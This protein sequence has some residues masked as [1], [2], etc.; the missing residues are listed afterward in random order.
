MA[1]TGI[2]AHHCGGNIRSGNL[3]VT[4]D[5]GI[6]QRDDDISRCFYFLDRF[7]CIYHIDVNPR[8]DRRPGG[9]KIFIVAAKSGYDRFPSGRVDGYRLATD[10]VTGRK[11]HIDTFYNIRIAL[12]LFDVQIIEYVWIITVINRVR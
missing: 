1:F 11:D 4:A 5:T 9:W 6:V 3:S 10:A 8:C 2:P 7:V 12:N